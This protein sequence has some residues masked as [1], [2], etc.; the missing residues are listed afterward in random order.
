M[1]NQIGF[2][3]TE[4][5]LKQDGL[6]GSGVKIYLGIENV[7]WNRGNLINYTPVTKISVSPQST[8]VNIGDSANLNR[9]KGIN[10][11]NGVGPLTISLSGTIDLYQLGS[12]S[13]SVYTITPGIL[14]TMIFNGHRTYR[15]WDQRIGS[16]WASDPN[17]LGFVQKPYSEAN[18]IPVVIIDHSITAGTSDNLLDYTLI[19][20]EDKE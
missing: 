14:Q 19:L 6:F 12:L 11:Y 15:Y 10:T 18:G 1:T 8:E 2:T 17:P 13:P 4:G 20:R 16:S 3:N 9:R 7:T 5:W